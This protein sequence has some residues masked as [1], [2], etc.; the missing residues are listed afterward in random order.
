MATVSPQKVASC[1][2]YCYIAGFLLVYYRWGAFFNPI[3]PGFNS[4]SSTLFLTISSSPESN[5]CQVEH[6]FHHV[7]CSDEPMPIIN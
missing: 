7:F 2:L 4:V 6:V 5:V 1:F 3:Q